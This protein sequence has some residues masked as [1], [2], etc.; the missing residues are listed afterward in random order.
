MSKES[1]N[2]N[3]INQ[4]MGTISV[5]CNECA[6]LNIREVKLMDPDIFHPDGTKSVLSQYWCSKC[7]AV[8]VIRYEFMKNKKGEITAQLKA[9]IDSTSISVPKQTDI[10]FI[11]RP[12]ATKPG[13]K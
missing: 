9:R 1:I 12:K 13:K 4:P 10:G 3:P 2:P 7:N 8:Q 6:A 11:V 5:K